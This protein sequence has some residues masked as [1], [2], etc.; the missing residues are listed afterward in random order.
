MGKFI[1]LKERTDLILL[2]Y[3]YLLDSKIRKMMGLDIRDNIIIF[4]EAHNIEGSAETGCSF[5]ISLKD[6]DS[7][8]K[9]F[10]LLRKK[11]EDNPSECRITRDE[12]EL[13]EYSITNLQKN[14]NKVRKD[15]LNESIFSENYSMIQ[16]FYRS[17]FE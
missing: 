6:L 4:D 17:I 2:P 15:Q 1:F 10:R 12:I 13:V 5:S 8:E 9:D 3:N 7:C 14:L 16:E 11:L